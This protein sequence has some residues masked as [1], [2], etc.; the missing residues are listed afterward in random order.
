[1]RCTPNRNAFTRLT[2]I[3]NFKIL[4]A[5]AWSR[6]EGRVP[7]TLP[8]QIEEIIPEIEDFYKSLHNGR[9]LIWQ[10]HLSNGTVRSF[11]VYC[12]SFIRLFIVPTL[13]PRLHRRRI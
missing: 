6:S 4:H 3:V 11:D 8:Y 12:H 9:K 5:G 13:F 7:I 10:H 2:D 1:M